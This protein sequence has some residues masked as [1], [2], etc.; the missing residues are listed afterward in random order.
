MQMWVGW[1]LGAWKRRLG[2]AMERRRMGAMMIKIRMR[3]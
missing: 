3:K 1:G 2:R